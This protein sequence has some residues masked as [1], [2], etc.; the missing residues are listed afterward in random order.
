MYGHNARLQQDNWPLVLIG[1]EDDASR[2][3][4][5]NTLRCLMDVRQSPKSSITDNI[6][7]A[8]QRQKEQYDH[9]HD[10]GKFIS[11]GSIV[12][13][14]NKKRIYWM[15]GRMKPRWIDPY[16]VIENPD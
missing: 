11:V 16:T 10:S 6:Q 14:M 1:D 2:A 7:A 15:G 8:Q 9:R 12:Y 3:Q 4:Y 13:A 5:D